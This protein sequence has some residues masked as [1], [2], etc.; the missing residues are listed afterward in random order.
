M[1]TPSSCTFM[2]WPSKNDAAE[3]TGFVWFVMQ[4]LSRRRCDSVD[5]EEPGG[6]ITIEDCIAMCGLTED[7]VWLSPSTSIFQK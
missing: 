5:G 3:A 7:E 4:E 6:M 2:L 1:P